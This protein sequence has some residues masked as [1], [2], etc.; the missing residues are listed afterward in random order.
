MAIGV[1]KGQLDSLIEPLNR[2]SA[3]PPAPSS[4][5][6]S[7]RQ[8]C[9]PEPSEPPHLQLASVLCE[10]PLQPISA[11][12]SARSFP[13]SLC[14]EAIQEVEYKQIPLQNMRPMRRKLGAPMM[15]TSRLPSDGICIRRPTGF[16]GSNMRFC[17][18]E[19][20]DAWYTT[21][22]DTHAKE[23]AVRAL[24]IGPGPVRLDTTSSIPEFLRPRIRCFD[25][26]FSTFFEF[27]TL[28]PWTFSF[29]LLAH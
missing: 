25:S 6:P 21:M 2:S 26:F 20:L 13:Q 27:L 7:A 16:G 4:A 22:L 10:L 14:I 23:L 24:P 12:V 28:R 9:T 5:P 15:H 19:D 17:C 29:L 8:L 11:P 1:A 18:G 3:V